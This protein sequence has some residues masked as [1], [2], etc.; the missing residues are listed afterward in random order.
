MVKNTS[1][2]KE[3]VVKDSASASFATSAS[4]ENTKTAPS[5]TPSSLPM[6]FSW[7]KKLMYRAIAAI[8]VLVILSK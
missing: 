4:S 5:F 3:T 7:I 8:I 6:D 1:V 2:Q